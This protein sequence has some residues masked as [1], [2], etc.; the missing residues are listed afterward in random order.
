[1]PRWNRILSSVLAG[2]LLA[3]LTACGGGDTPG[4]PTQSPAPTPTPC[5]QSTLDSD[6]ESID[7]KTLIYFDFSVPTNGRLDTTLDWTFTT[8]Q[9]GFYVVPANTC[10][11]AEF[12]TRSCTFLV[13][14]EASTLKPKKVSTPNFTAGNYRW[15]VGNF[16]SVTESYSLQVVL[17]SGGCAAMAAGPGPVAADTTDTTPQAARLVHR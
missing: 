10:T 3:G 4:G 9:M 13:R 8:S 7:A 1:M 5:T 14:S 16:A 17:S 11:L 15:I 2:A 12:N 6:A